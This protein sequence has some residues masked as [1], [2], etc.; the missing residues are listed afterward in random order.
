LDQDHCY[1]ETDPAIDLI[2]TSIPEGKPD[3]TENMAWT[4]YDPNTNLGIFGHL[5]RLQPNRRIWEGFS[6][7]YLPDGSAHASRSLGVSLSEARTGEY[8]YQPL[9]PGSLWRYSFNGVAQR[10]N[11]DDLRQRAIG[12]EPFEE[13]R[14]D[15]LFEAIEPIFNMHKSDHSSARMHLEHAG[16]MR[17][18]VKIGTQAFDI[19][20]TAYRDHSMS[21]RTFT[22]LDSETWVNAMFPSGRVLSLL[23]VSRG[24]RRILEGHTHKNGTMHLIHPLEIPAL[25][26]LAGNPANGTI[27]FESGGAHQAI[28]WDII[29]APY[30]PFQLLRPVGMRAGIDHTDQTSCVVLECP[31]KFIWDG[32]VGHGWLER[33][34]PLSG[35]AKV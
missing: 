32:E 6:L 27:T 15:L 35:L 19:D 28:Q 20:C 17:G 5:G 31:A 8:H 23:E 18:V 14:Y 13:A 16:R 2:R 21:Q 9:I 12:D 7:I 1:F 3:W 26:D 22:T 24:D 33:T 10:V 29:A 30:V 34:R 4:M 11:P 25:S